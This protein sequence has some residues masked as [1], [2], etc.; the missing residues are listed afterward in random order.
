MGLNK[1]IGYVLAITGIVIAVEICFKLFKNT[2][3]GKKCRRRRL[4]GIE[5][6]R[7]D[8]THVGEKAQ[9]Q[10]AVDEVEVPDDN[11]DVVLN[12]DNLML[13]IQLE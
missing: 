5:G 7:S 6:N 10:D 8:C 2:N 1:K 11:G 12:Q 4:M 9:M 13:I 3:D